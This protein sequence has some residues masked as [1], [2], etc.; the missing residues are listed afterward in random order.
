M[1]QRFEQQ[2]PST[3]AIKNLLTSTGLPN[4]PDSKG[5]ELGQSLL[6]PLHYAPCNVSPILP[7]SPSATARRPNTSNGLAKG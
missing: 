3:Y 4:T 7:Y 6:H 1:G 2:T 5:I